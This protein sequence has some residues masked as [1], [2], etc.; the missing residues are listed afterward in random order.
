VGEP[1]VD[2]LVD[3]VQGVAEGWWRLGLAG[4]EQGFED[5]VVDLGVEDREAEA[6]A[7]QVIGVCVGAG[8]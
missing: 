5:A 3:G 7:G 4:G 6:V 1:V 8:G 2:V